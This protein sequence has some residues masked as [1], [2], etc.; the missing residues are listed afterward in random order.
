MLLSGC[1]GMV[2]SLFTR[3]VA[4]EKLERFYNLL[5]TPVQPDEEIAKSC[6]LPEGVEPGPRHVFFSASSWEI[7]IPS[8]KALLGLAV[9]WG[10]VLAIIAVVAFW[11]AD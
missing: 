6:T 8:R 1:S 5:R 9:G 11:V 7:P 10:C 3:P 2:V 4:E